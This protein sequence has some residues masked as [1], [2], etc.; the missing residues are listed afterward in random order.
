MPALT[1]GEEMGLS[2]KLELSTA[3]AGLMPTTR[4][5]LMTAVPAPPLASAWGASKD[6]I[7]WYHSRA[8]PSWV[9][10]ANE[11]VLFH[12]DTETLW[13]LDNIYSDGQHA[14]RRMGGAWRAA[15]LGFA[16]IDD[17]VLLRLCVVQW[18]KALSVHR[19]SNSAPS[20]KMH[21]CIVCLDYFMIASTKRGSGAVQAPCCKHV[22]CIE[23]LSSYALA[24]VELKQWSAA[25]V[26]CPM[27]GCQEHLAGDFV[28]EAA[29][30]TAEQHDFLSMHLCRLLMVA[31]VHCPNPRCNALYDATND[32]EADPRVICYECREAFCRICRCPWHSGLTCAEYGRQLSGEDVPLMQLAEEFGWKRCGSCGSMVERLDGCNHMQCSVCSHHFCYRCGGP[33]DH[34]RYQCLNDNCGIYQERAHTRPQQHISGVVRRLLLYLTPP[35]LTQERRDILQ[36]WSQASRNL[37]DLSLLARG[38]LAWAILPAWQREIVQRYRCPYCQHVARHPFG[39]HI[40]A[41]QSHI[42]RSCPSQV[43][44]CCGKLFLTAEEMDVHV[45]DRHRDW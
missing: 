36:H 38:P 5:I 18:Q 37:V 28:L 45:R 20:D 16:T 34:E 21:Q 12:C 3:A 23:C 19:L 22:L 8:S 42:K 11:G 4:H 1:P 32:T 13:E 9:F 41:L 25:G 33:F 15:A 30:L 29:S 14:V 6:H 43:W 44:T 10:K 24:A 7:G 26:P 40:D 17:N 2:A 39:H 27:L 31:P 35:P